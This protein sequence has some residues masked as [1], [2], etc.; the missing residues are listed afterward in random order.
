MSDFHT[1]TSDSES[2]KEQKS[3]LTSLLQ[4]SP[5]PPDELQRNL[6]L[7]LL[8]QDLRRFL[9]FD[10]IYRHN[11]E[12]HG[13]ILDLGT[14]WGQT[15]AIFQALRA[16]HEPY[17]HNRKI[18]GFD[19]FEGFPEIAT[20]DGKGDFAAEG[21]YAVTKEYENYLHELLGCREQFSPLGHIPKYE[22]IKGDATTEVPAFLSQHTEIIVSLAYFDFD[23]Y[24]PTKAGLKALLPHLTKG[25]VLVFDELNHPEF[26]G[27]TQAV[28]EVLGLDKHTI[29]R[30]QYSQFQSYILYGQ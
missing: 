30:S 16:I 4:S 17:N 20:E 6:G 1:H 8:P 25:S 14:R 28:R 24:K 27:E 19:T 12:I 13:C 18:Y 21:S 23:L 26:P 9:F 22:L 2:D 29:R 11:L 5:L 3:S 10:E 7:Y 15:V